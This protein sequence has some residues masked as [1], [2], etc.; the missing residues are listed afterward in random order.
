[1]LCKMGRRDTRQ[2][3]RISYSPDSKY[4]RSNDG[5]DPVHPRIRGPCKH[6][7]ASRHQ[8]GTHDGR[9]QAELGLAGPLDARL[10]L[11][12]QRKTLADAGPQG[13]CSH[14][15]DEADANAQEGQADLPQ[16][17]RVVCSKD[18]REGPE[19]EV[20]NTEENGPKDAQAQAHWLENEQLERPQ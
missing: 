9:R 8:H 5:N 14:C 20:Q 19:E 15:G 13:T 12:F 3:D 7:D 10:L 16:V 17:E 2:S 11:Q 18:E 1:M 4:G 6:E